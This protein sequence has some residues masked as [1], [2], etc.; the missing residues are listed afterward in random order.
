MKNVRAKH[1]E[2]TPLNAKDLP[3]FCISF[4]MFRSWSDKIFH[5][6]FSFFFS[7]FSIYVRNGRERK[8]IL[9]VNRLVRITCNVREFTASMT[10]HIAHF[11]H[12]VFLLALKN[13]GCNCKVPTKTNGSIIGKSYA[14]FPSNPI[15]IR[16]VMCDFFSSGSSNGFMAISLYASTHFHHYWYSHGKREQNSF[17]LFKQICPLVCSMFRY[18]IWLHNID[19]HRSYVFK[20]NPH[21]IRQM[22]VLF[23]FL[24]IFFFFLF[25]VWFAVVIFT[26]T[27]WYLIR[28]NSV[29]AWNEMEWNYR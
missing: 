13:L 25:T 4:S 28:A 26:R 19:Q 7:F 29:C 17:H 9:A 14:F 12:Q 2:K 8:W 15:G 11:T 23:L 20:S 18:R 5:H 1:G 24:H 21:Y 22:I 3:F 27:Y 10:V 16:K 6:F